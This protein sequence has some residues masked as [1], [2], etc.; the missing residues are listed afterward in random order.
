MKIHLFH[1]TITFCNLQ[2]SQK[3]KTLSAHN[4]SFAPINFA[5]ITLSV[6]I[7]FPVLKLTHLSRDKLLIKES[8]PNHH[9]RP[10]AADDKNHQKTKTRQQRTI[11]PSHRKP[12]KK[13][14]RIQNIALSKNHPMR[15]KQQRSE[16][17]CK[18]RG[19]EKHTDSSINKKISMK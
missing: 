19:K 11:L 4:V 1:N 3:K 15:K 18:R 16:E 9:H 5:T 7:F 12:N 14:K 10:P 2:L 13:P 17:A 6:Y 8:E